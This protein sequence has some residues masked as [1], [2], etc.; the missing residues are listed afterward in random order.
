MIQYQNTL[1]K[2]YSFE[3]KGL[4]SGQ[5]VRMRLLPAPENAGIRFLRKDV[6]DDAYIP[7][8]VDYVTMTNRGTTLEK[9]GVKVSTIE[10]VLSC[11]YAMK[12]D[13]AVIELDNFEVP[14]L[15]GSALAYATEISKDGLQGQ[16]AE[17]RCYTVTETLHFQDETSGAELTIEPAGSFSADLT[18]DFNSKV[19]GVQTAHF[20]GNVDFATEIAP[21]RTFVFFH[22]LEFLFSNGLIKG[23]DL[24]NA[25]VIVENPVP[26]ETIKKMAT[27]FNVEKV[28]VKPD[29]YLDNVVP[30]FP[31]ECARHKMLDILGDFSL[32]GFPIKGKITAY[33]SG[34]KVNTEMAKLI[35][36][37]MMKGGKK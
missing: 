17:R 5:K 34:H 3:G 25:L 18:I 6:S 14:I 32:V 4:H 22:E 11:L 7:A 23:G 30:R 26:D 16:N 24:E 33:K 27:L 35:R 12:V 31:N 19:I 1:K 2:T 15:D 8:V 29:G 10:H 9:D 28:G 37:S 21:C 13:N 20:D 36:A